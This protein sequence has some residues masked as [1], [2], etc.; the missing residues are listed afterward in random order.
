MDYSNYVYDKIG[1]TKQLG[2]E[3]KYSITV[4]MNFVNRTTN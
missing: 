4:M 3:K 2:G 1:D